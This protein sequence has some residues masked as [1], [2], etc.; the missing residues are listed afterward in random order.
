VAEP[1]AGKWTA[2]ILWANGRAHLQEL[3]NIPSSYTGNISFRVMRSNFVT[4]Q[5]TQSPAISIPAHTSVSV[6]LGLLMA[7]TP[8]DNPESIQFLAANGAKT[9][10]PVARRTLIPSTGGAFQ[11]NITST[12]GRDIGA[13]ETFDINVP[14]GQTSLNVFFHT[15]DAS[16]DNPY[17]FYLINPA[18]KSV[19]TANSA[20]TTSNGVTQA[21]ATLSTS[22]PTGLAPGMWEI[23]V[24]LTLDTSGLEF[25]QV[26]F[27]DVEGG[28][29]EQVET[30]VT[31]QGALT[32][33]VPNAAPVVLPTPGLSTDGTQLVSNGAIN[34]VTIT[35]TRQSSPGWTASGSSTAFT[36]LGGGA[37]FASTFLGWTPGGVTNVSGTQAVTLGG[38]V[39]PTA[40]AGGGLSVPQVLATGAAGATGTNIVGATL[41]LAIP[42]STTLG[43]YSSTLTI[44]AI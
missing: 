5:A 12:V 18:G 15:A 23:D 10:L 4:S 1:L 24:A 7:A 21:T 42:S 2:K 34:P 38:V 27:G 26:V 30:T 32:L 20:A 22:V 28:G 40:T 9:S 3:P 25:Q 17:R 14:A 8:G 11:A 16:A 39:A 13:I 6:P 36:N 41:N 29:A 37:G 19:V 33:S 43:T 44:T 31:Q 35:D